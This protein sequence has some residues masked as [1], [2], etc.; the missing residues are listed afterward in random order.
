MP[1]GPIQFSK[2]DNVAVITLN[3]PEARNA[4]TPEMTRDLGAAVRSCDSKD[5]RAVLLTGSG[6]AFCSGADVKVFLD[7][8]ENGGSEALSQHIREMAGKLHTEVVLGL[9]RLEKPVVAAINGVA[10][11]AGFS[12]MLACDI[13]IA[14][15]SARFVMAYANIGA[16]ADG[17][18][19]AFIKDGV[20][21]ATMS[22]APDRTLVALTTRSGNGKTSL[23]VMPATVTSSAVE[24]I[25]SAKSTERSSP[26]RTRMSPRSTRAKPGG[27]AVS[28]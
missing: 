1:T 19:I 11:G 14:A 21:V 6:E 5:V 7:Q 22:L 15:S 25:G 27:P 3:R 2:I 16:T 23:G 26:T 20:R 10:A 9:L 12:L 24:P 8:L 28:L 17:D 18:R 4:L 13:R